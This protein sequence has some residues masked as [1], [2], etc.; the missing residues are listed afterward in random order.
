MKTIKPQ[1]K[2]M[3]GPPMQPFCCTLDA[4]HEGPHIARTTDGREIARWNE[5]NQTPTEAGHT[6]EPW[7]FIRQDNMIV[8]GN[9]LIGFTCR[10]INM[11][12]TERDSDASRI[13]AC[14]NACAGLSDPAAE[15][16]RLRLDRDNA[17]LLLRQERE[18]TE[19]LAEHLDKT[20]NCINA[21]LSNVSLYGHE[22]LDIHARKIATEA[23]KY[24]IRIKNVVSEPEPAA[25]AP[26]KGASK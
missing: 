4:G 13:V 15:L 18:R 5:P 24:L 23:S 20:K 12:I 17:V 6:P 7:S 16:A 14:V 3:A 26:E 19:T 2:E 21:I 8:A 11:S 22:T 1:C 25:L 10:S 9:R